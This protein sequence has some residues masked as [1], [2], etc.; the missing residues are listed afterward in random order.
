MRHRLLLLFPASSYRVEAFL[1][2]AERTG[3]DLWLGT[4]LPAA[5]TR[6]GRPT[7]AI[8]FRA[9][10]D[11]A[12]VI[13]GVA[14]DTPFAGIVATNESS[15][16][17][18]ALAA[19]RLGLPC[20]SPEGALAARD[21][22][23]MR[24]LLAAHGVPSPAHRVL[25]PEQGPE[26]I[27]GEV[28]FPCVVKPPMLTGSQGVIR[29]DGPEE[30]AR[31]VA[32]V[33]RILARHGSDARSAPGFLDVIVEDYLPGREVAVEGLM[34]AGELTPLAIFDKPDDLTGPF[35]EETIYV[36][37]SRLPP[38]AQAD[39][40]DVAGRAARALGLH[41]GPVHVELRTEGGR[42]AV[43]ELAARSIGGLCSQVFR[44]A[45]GP[46]EDLLLAHAAGLPL[47]APA[48][49]AGAAAAGVMMVPIP[50]SGVLKRVTGLDEARAV[51][52]I[53]G[54][55]IAAKLGE[56]VHA[57]PEGASYLGFVFA[58]GATPAAVESALRDAHAC[59]AFEWA[60]LLELW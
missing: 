32:R 53:D 20:S 35:F 26:A 10:E 40:L 16:V 6:H 4:D 39:L 27:A 22:R 37:P 36:T 42:A 29:A 44:L 50:R 59:L 56:A 48:R 5:F 43:V 8:D 24:A 28:R 33:R 49:E 25:T 57:L 34:T 52:G 41:H 31:A 46:L 15:A 14:A 58:R 54:V 11:A 55:T 47:P 1:E 38:A 21:K 18:A 17:V 30:L 51:P 19:A 2:A 23:R 9:P 12:A 13:A 60:P 3:V 45:A 7:V